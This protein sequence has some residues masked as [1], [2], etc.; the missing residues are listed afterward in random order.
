MSI[1]DAAH[2]GRKRHV[3]IDFE[4]LSTNPNAAVLSL[5]AVILTAGGL[6]G[7][8]FYTN[9]DGQDC[10]NLG[11]HV[12]EAT[13]TWWAGQ[14]QEAKDALEVDKKPLLQAM[15][16]F[17][18][19]VRRTGGTH[20]WGNG[21]DFDNPILKSCFEAINADTPFKPYNGRC[22]RTIKSIP[23]VPKMLKR[24]G[25]HHNALDDAKSQAQHLLEIN[26]FIKVL[27]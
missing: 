20:L 2:I 1:Q 3:M 23:G 5:G 22:Y 24:F 19:W 11:L 13:V 14:S 18:Q 9:I 21:A 25:T 6:T 15:T 12:S 7:D 27:E 10:I 17:S 4:T 26:A 8:E 16:A